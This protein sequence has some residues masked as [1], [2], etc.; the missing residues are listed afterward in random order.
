MHYT[1]KPI[2]FVHTEGVKH[3]D[4]ENCNEA[5]ICNHPFHFCFLTS[6]RYSKTTRQ[7]LLRKGSQEMFLSFFHHVLQW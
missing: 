1:T 7:K 6:T 4:V 5:I 3:T 2:G